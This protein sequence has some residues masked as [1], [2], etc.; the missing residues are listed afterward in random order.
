LPSATS[1]GLFDLVADEAEHARGRKQPEVRQTARVDEA[2]D[3][4][5]ER[6]Q[7]AD[8]DREHDRNSGPAFAA[9]T[10]QVE[11]D[12]QRDRCQR[13]SEVVD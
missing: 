11:G 5:T 12:P 6:D 10:S 3:R 13:V 2:I 7:R 8:E 4:L 9:S 1:A